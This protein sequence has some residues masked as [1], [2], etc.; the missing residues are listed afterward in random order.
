MQCLACKSKLF[1]NRKSTNGD[2]MGDSPF[3]IIIKNI[4]LSDL[5]ATISMVATHLTSTHLFHNHYTR[6][7]RSLSKTRSTYPSPKRKTSTQV[8]GNQLSLNSCQNTKHPV[9]KADCAEMKI[10]YYHAAARKHKPLK[11]GRQNLHGWRTPQVPQC[12]GSVNPQHFSKTS[13][14]DTSN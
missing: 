5:D 3:I 4:S 11:T 7:S 13:S 8:R 6:I 12:H 14:T 9:M 10:P 1:S 2:Q